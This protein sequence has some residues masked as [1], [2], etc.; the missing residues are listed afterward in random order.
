MIRSVV[1]RQLIGL[2]VEREAAP[3]NAVAVPTDDGAKERAP[4]DVAVQVVESEHHVVESSGAI[5]DSD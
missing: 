5:G 3:G 1:G 4:L 2:A